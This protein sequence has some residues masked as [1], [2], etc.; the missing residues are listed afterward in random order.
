MYLLIGLVILL[1]LAVVLI[2]IMNT[3]ITR[4]QKENL[5]L[6]EKIYHL[7]YAGREKALQSDD[8]PYWHGAKNKFP[9]VYPVF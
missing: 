7:K 1:T 9:G 5:K 2:I 3:I 4:L 8:E 6:H